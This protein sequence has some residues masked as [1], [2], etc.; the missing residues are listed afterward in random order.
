M[1]YFAF[2]SSQQSSSRITSQHLVDD[3]RQLQQQGRNR[4]ASSSV[5]RSSPN[6][7]ALVV[8]V[9]CALL[10]LFVLFS[11]RAHAEAAPAFTLPTT[12]E[13]LSL[14]SLKGKVVYL[15]FWASWCS[16]CKKSFPWM[17]KMQEKYG[18]QGLVIV[19]ANMDQK[20][21]KADEFIASSKPNFLIAFD[22]EGAVAEKYQLVGMPTSYL[23]DRKGELHS[24]HA[25]FREEDME[26]LEKHIRDLLMK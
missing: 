14:A 9:M 23:I 8:Q 5:L 24:S 12:K 22:P 6:S 18:D 2:F 21:E 4:V 1:R 20:R 17:K 15:D 13:K 25:G 3:F 16:P 26:K 19:A 11:T 10:A 7:N